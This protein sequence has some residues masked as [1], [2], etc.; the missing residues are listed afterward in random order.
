[1]GIPQGLFAG[2]RTFDEF[3]CATVPQMQQEPLASFP[4]HPPYPPETQK[5]NSPPDGLRGL[6]APGLDP[7]GEEAAL[8]GL[9][10]GLPRGEEEAP[11]KVLRKV[12]GSQDFSLGRVV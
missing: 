1:M 6:R 10:R 7:H 4:L 5:T 8:H 12:Q 2:F 3:G 9:H 11:R